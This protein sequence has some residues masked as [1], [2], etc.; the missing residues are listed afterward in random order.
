MIHVGAGR[1]GLRHATLE[2]RL[3]LVTVAFILSPYIY[4][5]TDLK[6]LMVHLGGDQ[7]MKLN[8][9][10]LSMCCEKAVMTIMTFRCVI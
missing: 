6:R 4:I 5:K 7:T 8:R 1:F 10:G 3:C 2:S 9:K